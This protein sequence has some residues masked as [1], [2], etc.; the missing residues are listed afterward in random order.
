MQL[1]RENRRLRRHGLAVVVMG[2]LLA[3]SA[4]GDGPICPSGLVVVIEAPRSDVTEDASAAPGV[5]V[6]VEVRSNLRED[7]TFTLSIRDDSGAEIGTASTTSDADGNAVFANVTLPP[8]TAALHVEGVA[9][10]CGS[11]TDDVAVRVVG[12]DGCPLPTLIGP[13]DTITTD[14]DGDPG[15][16]VQAEI[17]LGLDSTCTAESVTVDCGVGASD[18][19]V[20]NGEATFDVT[21][22]DTPTCE[23]ALQCTVT[24]SDAFGVETSGDILLRVDNRPPVVAVSFAQ[25]LLLSCGGQVTTDDDIDL[26]TSGVQLEAIVV[27][28]NTSDQQIRVTNG[29]SSE[30]FLSAAG[31]NTVITVRPGNNDLVA[32][33]TD[34]AGNVGQS[35]ICRVSL[36]DLAV[37]FAA[38][39]ADGFANAREGVV[40]GS[41]L[42]LDICG[43]V[44][45]AGASVD[46][47]VDSGAVQAATVVGT[48]WCLDDVSLSAGPHTIDVTA[49][50]GP[51]TGLAD[52]DLTVDFTSP[53]DIAALVG[54]SPNRFTA[55]L[56]W[57]APSDQGL[58]VDGYVLKVA[59]V[60]LDSGNFDDTGVELAAPVPLGPGQAQ[61]F[62]TADLDPGTEYYFAL[63]A[64][65]R[66]G[67]RSA[68]ATAGPI[69]PDLDPTATI[70][71][72]DPGV[73][74]SNDGLGFQLVRGDFNDDGFS[75]VAVSAPARGGEDGMSNP[76]P[77]LGAVYIYFGSADG[78][79]D[80]IAPDVTIN[81]VEAG[82]AFG[83]GMTALRWNDDGI[84]DLA[85]SA[86]IGDGFN[87]QV[88]IFH[89][90]S[91]LTSATTP[92][93]ASV[94]I[95]V[96]STNVNNWF[97]GS[98]LGWSLSS[99]RFDSDDRDD[100]VIVAP[101]GGNTGGVGEAG[102][103]TVLFGGTAAT[104]IALSSE[105]AS[106]SGDARAL[107]IR[108]PDT[109]A[110]HVLFGLFGETLFNLGRTQGA[111]DDDDD[112]GVSYADNGAA[113]VIRGR[114]Q[115]GAAGVVLADYDA[116]RDLTIQHD[117]AVD[118]DFYF[119][120][121]MGAI[122]DTNADGSRDIVVGAWGVTTVANET[123]K[124]YIIDGDQVGTVGVGSA[125]T[126]INGSIG[127]RHF[128]TSIANNAAASSV[129]DINGDGVEDLV[130][131][132]GSTTRTPIELVVWYG[133][134]IPTGTVT[135]ATADHRIA[136]PAE[137]TA[138]DPQGTAATPMSLIWAGDVNNDGLEDV[139]W[140]DHKSNSADGSLVLLW[141]DGI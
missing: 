36:V 133:G 15:N 100:L 49:S 8:E 88:F 41:T 74:D 26:T 51:R 59:T 23:D 54:T 112:F 21:L 35:T 44:S 50:I 79:G 12:G 52:L 31:G 4:C 117:G 48:D 75:D 69:R 14:N 135:E 24:V 120:S 127:R 102:G 40:S 141:D 46:V 131:S 107:V 130:L 80:P 7:D 38:D 125:L 45:E 65:D 94:L 71:S 84:D 16:G 91:S 73:G 25:P 72:S 104:S 22:C 110:S 53:G 93:D 89:G 140:A 68:L 134:N 82:A 19:T 56:A 122:P 58:T 97:N 137:F 29:A 32:S 66:A 138:A 81:G 17:T 106:G 60:P 114:A 126:T 5:Q 33:A 3:A 113:L 30:D 1:Y 136:A 87:G 111:G 61:S 42:T 76:L 55:R 101:L 109:T 6:D 18:G 67:N 116:A 98:F 105:D 132:A 47:S 118:I 11:A 95:S 124:V 43:S 96:N 129:P 103:L 10:E 37:N 13:T 139:C 90:G 63:A 28:P 78:F 108:D 39:I 27:A 99:G 123:G 121:A 62:S 86:P 115:P 83:R 77:A 119:G 34:T 128:G 20:V 57:N 85:V 64:R 70:L 2:L 9:D 92:A